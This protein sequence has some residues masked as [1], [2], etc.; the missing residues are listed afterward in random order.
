MSQGQVCLLLPPTKLFMSRDPCGPSKADM[1]GIS[2][3]AAFQTLAHP[4]C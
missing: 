1:E 2:Y 3:V 4:C